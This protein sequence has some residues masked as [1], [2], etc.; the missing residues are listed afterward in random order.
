MHG[1]YE[2]ARMIAY[3][4]D[5]DMSMED[6]HKRILQKLKHYESEQYMPK[7]T[8]TMDKAREL[9][10]E[11]EEFKNTTKSVFSR[12]IVNSDHELKLYVVYSYGIHHPMW[13]YDE[14]TEQWFGNDSSPSTTTS[15]HATQT[16]PDVDEITMLPTD[17]LDNILDAG[18]YA[19]YCAH[20]C[21]VLNFNME[22]T[23][24]HNSII[25]AANA[26]RMDMDD[27]IV[28]ELEQRTK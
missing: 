4:S 27:M 26:M 28:S 18:S 12:R 22:R 7:M 6:K 17:A 10:M 1:Q 15:K 13:V 9:I 8:A 25:R 20:R 2:I 24:I 19:E 5:S 21:G 16:K 14:E 23:R 3:F 11:H